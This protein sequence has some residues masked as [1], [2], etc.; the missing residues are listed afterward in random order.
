MELSDCFTAIKEANKD[1]FTYHYW[2]LIGGIFME[3]GWI[4]CWVKGVI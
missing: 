2:K 1:A 4:A 3:A